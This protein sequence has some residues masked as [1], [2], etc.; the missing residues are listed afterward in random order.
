VKPSRVVTNAYVDRAKVRPMETA[1]AVFHETLP[2][3]APTSLRPAPECAKAL[4]VRSVHVKDESMRVG[5]PAFKILGASWATYRVMMAHFGRTPSAAPSLAELRELVRASGQDLTLVAATDGNHGRAVA[6]MAKL[7]GLESIILVPQ[8][9]VESRKKAI[10]R[11]GAQVRVV[12]G[13]YDLAIQESAALADETH[14]VVSDTSW[15][16]YTEAPKWVIDGYS[17]ML[18]EVIAR[19]EAGHAP[20]PSV[21]VAQMG[22]GAF[23]AAVAAAFA[24]RPARLLVGVEPVTADCVT[25]S[26]E[27][28]EMTTLPDL[29]GT[30]MAGLDC[31]T[32][33]LTAWPDNLYGFDH[34]VTVTDEDAEEA[35]RLLYRDY[36]N[37]GESGAAGL[38]ALL[39]H[40]QELGLTPQDDVL[41]FLTEGVTDPVNF[42]RILGEE[43]P[44]D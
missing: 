3:F 13:D 17:T 7:L 43:N 8:S 34:L 2:G 19:V 29:P 9:M 10:A 12:P 20:E 15:E 41:V 36:I 23:S 39:A 21:V 31:G 24:P 25:A 33:S 5:M 18:N 28:G 35:T 16:G 11:N 6:R 44:L 40:G 1:P 30:A 27:A 14:I 32:P 37:A 42:A 22:V 4:G 26:V 38:A